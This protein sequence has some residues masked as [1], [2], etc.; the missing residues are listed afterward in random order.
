MPFLLVR[1]SFYL[2]ATAPTINYKSSDLHVSTITLG[3]CLPTH[4]THEVQPLDVGVFLPLTVQWTKVCHELYQ[5]HPSSVVTKL[6]F[7][8]LF[9]QAWCNAVTPA[10]VMSG[11]RRAGVHPFNPNAITVTENTSMN[12]SS[13]PSRDKS[14]DMPSTSTSTDVLLF[15]S[16]LQ[17][18]STVQLCRLL[19]IVQLLLGH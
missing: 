9:L 8:C 13:T 5:K 15:P 17:L 1:S 19:L 18:L 7:S 16:A 4:T 3:L 10:N 14:G 12:S 2:M 11:F 6:K